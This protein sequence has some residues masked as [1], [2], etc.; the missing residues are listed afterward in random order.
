MWIKRTIF[1]KILSLAKEKPAILLTGSRQTGKSSLL[2][3][4]FPQAEYVSFDSPMTCQEAESNPE[5]FLNQFQGQVILDEIQY[6]PLLFR[7]LKIKIDDKIE[8]K[9]K[10]IL[11]GS[12]KFVLMKEV[13]ETLAGRISILELDTLSV[14]EIVDSEL[15]PETY[16]LRGGYPELWKNPQLDQ[17][18]FFQDYVQTYIERDLRRILDVSNLRAFDRFIRST[19]FRVS[20]LVNFSDLT[21]DAAITSATGKNWYFAL[22][23]SN[24]CH[25]LEP[26]FANHLKR[27]IKSPKI[28][29][30]DCGLLNYLV[31]IHGRDALESSQLHGALFEN[32]VFNQIFRLAEIKNG[33]RMFHYYRDKHGNEVDFLIENGNKLTLIEVKS[34]ENPKE[35]ILNLNKIANQIGDKYVFRKI[36]MNKIQSHKIIKID[37]VEVLNPFFIK[38]PD[39]LFN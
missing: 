13:T 35:A 16:F 33:K 34:S 23:A 6:V 31:N 11:T 7:Y 15:S 28:Y 5:Q 2:K 8:E 21:R 1:E 9:G 14:Q 36:V 19:A 38:I 17:K 26:F 4:L 24:I 20:N 29:F 25:S 22:E 39:D 10:W 12:Q 32:F 18:Q 37:D 3:S 30:R 27:L